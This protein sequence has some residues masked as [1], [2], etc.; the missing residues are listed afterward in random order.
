MQK[1]V[2][3][4]KKETNISQ[5]FYRSVSSH[6]ASELVLDVLKTRSSSLKN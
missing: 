4:K 3:K 2:L 6:T 5:K 1:N